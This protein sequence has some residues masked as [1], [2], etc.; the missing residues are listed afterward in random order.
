MLVIPSNNSN[1]SLDL[2]TQTFVGIEQRKLPIT[3]DTFYLMNCTFMLNAVLFPDKL[4]DLE[5]RVVTVAAIEYI[6][7]AF[8][9]RKANTQFILIFS[10]NFSNETIENDKKT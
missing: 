2:L 7:Y 9:E 5:G 4:N 3:L 6:P 10:F 8:I 1:D